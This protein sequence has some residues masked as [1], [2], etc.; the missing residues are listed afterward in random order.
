MSISLIIEP[1]EL[2]SL[3]GGDD[4]VIVDLSQPGQYVNAH[5][6]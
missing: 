6:P 4:T 1:D 2:E 5:I 3:R